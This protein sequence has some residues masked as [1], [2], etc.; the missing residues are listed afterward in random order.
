MSSLRKK[1]FLFFLFIHKNTCIYSPIYRYITMTQLLKKHVVFQ[2]GTAQQ[3][4]FN[5]AKELLQS[6]KV[7]VHYDQKK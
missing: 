2:W 4:A 6:H 7:L 3:T 5:K 1:T